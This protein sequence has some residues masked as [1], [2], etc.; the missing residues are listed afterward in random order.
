MDVNF[1]SKKSNETNNICKCYANDSIPDNTSDSH[2]DVWVIIIAIYIVV[3]LL[4]K[5]IETSISITLSSPSPAMSCL[6]TG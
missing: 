5:L 2:F 1:E 3:I 4:I 6:K